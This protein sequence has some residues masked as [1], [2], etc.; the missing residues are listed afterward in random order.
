MHTKLPAFEPPKALRNCHLQSI[1]SNR[2]PRSW[3]VNKRCAPMLART[4]QLLLN[5]EN[6]TKL[7]AEFNRATQENDKLAVLLHGWEGSSESTY[8]LS[9]ALH[10]FQQNFNVLRVN[11]RDH[12]NSRHLNEALFNSTLTH[13]V[14]GAITDFQRS[15]P[16]RNN[17][18]AGFSLGGSFT[19]RMAA[20]SGDELSLNTAVAICPPVDPAHAMD[21]LMSG[22][23][24]HDHFLQKWRASLQNKLL[25]YPELGYQDTLLQCNSLGALHDF[26]VPNFTPYDTPENYFS[27][28]ALTG[29]RLSQLSLAAYLITSSDDPIVPV[30]DIALM[31]KP[32]ALHIET[33]KFGGH[34][35]FIENYC[36]ESWTDKRLVEIFSHH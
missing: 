11:L 24:Y 28:Y 1:L 22:G 27:A 10:L 32:S 12:G 34:C 14:T 18:L 31:N 35:G 30:T 20:D 19:L 26:F 9:A 2:G 5:G 7:L 15:Q 16:H 29:D 8:I 3:L 36:L 6:G 17:Y 21:K 4:Q 13:E 25:Y 23:I 33:T